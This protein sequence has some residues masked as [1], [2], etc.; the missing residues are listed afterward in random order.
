MLRLK[1]GDGPISGHRKK[2]LAEES[3]RLEAAPSAPSLIPTPLHPTVETEKLFQTKQRLTQSASSQ[4]ASF[5]SV[6]SPP[7]I[8]TAEPPKHLSRRT[9]SAPTKKKVVVPFRPTSKA[10]SSY[11][12]F[13][14]LRQTNVATNH[15]LKRRHA[16]FFP[17][18]TTAAIP[19]KT[20]HLDLFGTYKYKSDPYKPKPKVSF[21]TRTRTQVPHAHEPA[22]FWQSTLLQSL[23]PQP[24]YLQS[25]K[26]KNAGP[27]FR[28]NPPSKTTYTRS[29]SDMN[30]VRAVVAPHAPIG[31]RR[32]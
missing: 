4:P 19:G 13:L 21:M 11:F 20:S 18:Q 17:G 1:S 29:I 5:A 3:S 15:W 10:K 30:A 22:K 12:L 32:R 2:S 16:L 25:S 26:S 23:F 27:A 24:I 8:G 6:F 7:K 14:R 9:V 28:P 31:P